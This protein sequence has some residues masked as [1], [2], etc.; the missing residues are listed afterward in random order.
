MGFVFKKNTITMDLNGIEFEVDPILHD[1]K[2]AEFSSKAET[3]LLE[4]EKEGFSEE[5]VTAYL[6]ASVEV[7]DSI[8]GEGAVKKIYKEKPVDYVSLCDL[9]GYIAGEVRNFY[10]RRANSYKG[11]ANNTV[12]GMNR[13]ERR[14]A[15]K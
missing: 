3:L 7:L 11:Q 9:M 6:N 10:E 14:R 8:L 13:A 5:S 1:R 12:A 2:K 15:R 4:M